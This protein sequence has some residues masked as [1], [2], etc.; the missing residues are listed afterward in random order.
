MNSGGG[1]RSATPAPTPDPTA[2]RVLVRGEAVAPPK[3]RADDFAW[4]R[5][6][7]SASNV[8]D[9]DPSLWP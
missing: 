1:G 7:G 9:A 4:P 3:G 5:P 8:P 2:A 6:S